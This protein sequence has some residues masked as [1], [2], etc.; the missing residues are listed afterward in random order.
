MIATMEMLLRDRETI[1]PRLESL[2]ARMQEGLERLLKRH[3]VEA[4]V[5]R[6][7][8][9]FCVYFMG[10]EPRDWYDLAKHHNIARDV[11][12]RRAL[13]EKGVYHFPLAAKQGSLSTAHLESDVDFTLEATDD[14]LRAGI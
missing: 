5:A 10:H 7:G 4:V 3:G 2:G 9:A 8:S 11:R 14:A 1:Y 13:I 12:Y 6:Q